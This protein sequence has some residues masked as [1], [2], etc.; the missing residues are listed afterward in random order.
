[1]TQNNSAII[2]DKN[3]ILTVAYVS[4]VFF[5]MILIKLLWKSIICQRLTL[6][7]PVVNIS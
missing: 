5:V 1:M 3:Y 2:I 6:I 7:T 4:I